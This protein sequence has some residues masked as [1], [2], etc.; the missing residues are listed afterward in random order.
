MLFSF[1][2]ISYNQKSRG[3]LRWV[4][5]IKATLGAAALINLAWSG[6]VIWRYATISFLY[7]FPQIVFLEVA[8]WSFIKLRDH[9]TYRNDIQE[10]K[11]RVII[12]HVTYRNHFIRICIP[13]KFS[14]C[15][16]R[17]SCYTIFLMYHVIK[18]H[19]IWFKFIFE[20]LIYNNIENC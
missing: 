3:L 4:L 20:T 5:F 6:H 15:S 2:R 18:F 11:K 19:Q 14:D 8:L 16:L 12:N 9:L 10:N 7:L 17:E 1:V 13:A